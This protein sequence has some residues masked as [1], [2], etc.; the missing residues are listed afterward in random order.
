MGPAHRAYFDIGRGFGP[1]DLRFG[2]PGHRIK[3]KLLIF[4]V[5]NF[6]ILISLIT[7]Y[8]IYV[9]IIILYIACIEY[10][11]YVCLYACGA[12]LGEKVF[13]NNTLTSRSRICVQVSL[14][15]LLL[16]IN[17]FVAKSNICVNKCSSNMVFTIFY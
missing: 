10:F 6:C 12:T 16:F 13:Q 7:A 11:S 15:I 9:P 17:V 2:P 5:L 14:I 3:N 4:T 8:I 1:R